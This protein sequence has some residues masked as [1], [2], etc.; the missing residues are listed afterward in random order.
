MREQTLQLDGIFPEDHVSPYYTVMHFR[1]VHNSEGELV[2]NIS[3]QMQED[4]CFQPA[5]TKYD[6]ISQLLEFKENAWIRDVREALNNRTIAPDLLSEYHLFLST[7][8]EMKLK[9]LM[10]H[11]RIAVGHGQMQPEELEKIM[12]HFVNGE[13]DILLST[14]IIESGIDIPNANTIIIDRADRFGLSELYQLRGRV[15]RYRNQAFAYLLIP[16]HAALLAD[17]RK[18]IS[19][20]KQYSRLGSGFKIAMRDLEIR[21]AGNI[22][23]SEQSGHISAIGFDLYCRLLKRSISNLKGEKAKTHTETRIMLD[24]LTQLPLEPASTPEDTS[25]DLIPLSYINDPIQRLEIYRRLAQASCP[26]EIDSI[27]E[28]LLDRFGK[29]PLKV[30]YLID[31][32]LIRV[33]ASLKQINSIETDDEKIIITRAGQPLMINNYYPRFTKKTPRGRLKE[34]LYLIKSLS[35]ETT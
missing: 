23:G 19:A 17:A 7:A 22:L 35:S 16:R 13:V 6:V 21:G 10:P 18:R 31:L 1:E 11:A 12:S 5:I 27:N 20:I 14:T 26:D 33:I 30:Q 4:E 15:G 29:M 32:Y 9:Q 2:S 24:F 34:L 3:L 8:M 25:N 28:E